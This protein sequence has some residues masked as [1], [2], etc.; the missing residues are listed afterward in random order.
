MNNK[1]LA[2]DLDGTLIRS[3][4]L[5]EGLLKLILRKPWITIPLIFKLFQGKAAFKNYIAS[6]ADI[7]CINLPYNNK[8]I[9]FIK[10]QKQNGAYLILCTASN[11]RYAEKIFQYLKIFNEVM[12]SDAN[13]NLSG[14]NKSQALIEKFGVGGFDYI[15]N[16]PDD[17]AVW[18]NASKAILVRP[19][20]E[21][22]KKIKKINANFE[23]LDSDSIT[24]LSKII[25]MLRPHQWL[26]NLLIFL[27]FLTATDY[28]PN[29]ETFFKLLF[30][31]MS[32]S[33]CASSVYILNDLSDIESDREHIRKRFRSLAS[34]GV[35]I[36]LAAIILPV[37]F[38]LSLMIAYFLPVKFFF[39]LGAYFFL[40][41]LYSFSLKKMVLIDCFML[42]ILYTIRIVAGA[43]ALNL[44]LTFWL[45]L[46]S[47]TFF[48]SLSF[49]KRASELHVI[50]GVSVDKIR[51]RGY[52]VKDYEFIQ[53]LGIC[54][55]VA[56]VL[57]F[58]LYLNTPRAIEV[59]LNHQLSIL[60]I[61][62]LLFWISRVWLCTQR[63]QMH[64]DPVIYAVKDPISICCGAIF[65]M[66]LAI[67]RFGI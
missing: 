23:I 39:I 40:T 42:A 36:Y 27:P 18:A 7:D 55:G 17:F 63:G 2:V 10:E 45:L 64:D 60:S 43:I 49:V 29:L 59:Y 25:S 26:K 47:F 38:S 51:G 34:G 46:F 5:V 3:D 66:I 1:I 37:L 28:T 57:L 21:I 30:A 65:V 44:D 13:L 4:L 11:Y 20:R 61:P 33:I 54:S 58:A 53:C 19:T 56:S 22:H 52:T 50:G 8:V 35:Q 31:F 12:A 67:A 15:G 6:V 32:F 14:K 16:S 9:A 62:I 48:L 24:D 41:I